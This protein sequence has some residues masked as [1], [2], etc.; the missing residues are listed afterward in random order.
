MTTTGTT[1][2]PIA[3]HQP[4][5]AAGRPST[6]GQTDIPDSLATRSGPS[7]RHGSVRRQERPPSPVAG[8]GITMHARKAPPRGGAFV[9]LRKV[10]D[11]AKASD[12]GM[13][14]AS[15]RL[16]DLGRLRLKLV[17]IGHGALRMRGRGKD[18][19]LVVGPAPPTTTR[20]SSRDRRAVRVRGRCRD[21]R[22]GSMRQAR[23]PVLRAR[24]RCDPLRSG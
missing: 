7:R 19:A 12:A 5:A 3:M 17:Q 20:G 16:A 9:L 10:N 2:T 22:R 15:R 1:T 21:R 18:E 4:S 24:V 8:L 11:Q 14:S 6:Q 23:R 13:A